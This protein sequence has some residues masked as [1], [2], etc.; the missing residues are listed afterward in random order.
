MIL[1]T[2]L[3]LW[4]HEALE[5]FPWVNCLDAGLLTVPKKPITSQ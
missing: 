2:A 5:S 1:N 4:H 3:P